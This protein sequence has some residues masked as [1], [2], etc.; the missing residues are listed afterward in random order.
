MC[1]ILCRARRGELLW[2]G[3]GGPGWCSVSNC[4]SVYAAGQPTWCCAGWHWLGSALRKKARR[5][6]FST[7][8]IQS[9]FTRL[10]AWFGVRVASIWAR[11]TA[12]APATN[13][14]SVAWCTMSNR[15]LV[16]WFG[17]QGNLGLVAVARLGR[18]GCARSG[19]AARLASG[20]KAQ[21]TRQRGRKQS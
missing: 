16:R 15:S 19:G 5:K 1:W 2:S 10:W 21:A 6:G 3:Q 8:G 7:G 20:A 14:D 17:M 18:R 12:R 11:Y 13:R 4:D 9:T